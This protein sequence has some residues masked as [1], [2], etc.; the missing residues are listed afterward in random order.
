MNTYY[1]CKDIYDF[2]HNNAQKHSLKYSMRKLYSVTKCVT[3]Y[4]K[5]CQHGKIVKNALEY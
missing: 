5:S 1:K 4:Y 3:L 2:I